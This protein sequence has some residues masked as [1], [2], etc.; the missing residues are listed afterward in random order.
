MI[1][2]AKLYMIWKQYNHKST[3]RADESRRDKNFQILTGTYIPLI[4]SNKEV[5]ENV[6]IGVLRD[7]IEENRLKWYGNTQ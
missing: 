2:L 1:R 4:K 6:C 3:A 7:K 5:R